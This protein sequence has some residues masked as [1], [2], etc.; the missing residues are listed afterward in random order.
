MK[1]I[2]L[3]LTVLSVLK[4]HAFSQHHYGLKAGINFSNQNKTYGS[5]LGSAWHSLDTKPFQ[6]YQ[7]GAFYK[8]ALNDTWSFS[9]EVNLS[10]VGSKAQYLTEE[11]ILNGDRVAHYFTDKIGYI[12]VPLTLQYSLNKLYFGAGPSIGY[13]VFS[14]I[15]KFESRTYNSPYFRKLDVAANLLTGYRISDKW[16]VNLRYSHGLLNVYEYHK[17]VKTKNYFLNLSMLYFLK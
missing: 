8:A 9:A 11:M 4:Q 3:L 13:K 16:D 7:L 12:E 10:V 6:G 17:Y 2:F 5:F 14:K 1:K 15:K